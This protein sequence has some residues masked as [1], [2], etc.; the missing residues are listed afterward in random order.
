MI[1]S[2]KNEKHPNPTCKTRARGKAST[3][4]V[5]AKVKILVGRLSTTLLAKSIAHASIN[6]TSTLRSKGGGEQREKRGGR[7]DVKVVKKRLGA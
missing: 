4:P 7:S 5:V 1:H 2:K 6:A 3:K